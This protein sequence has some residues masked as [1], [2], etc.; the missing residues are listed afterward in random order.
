MGVPASEIRSPTFAIAVEH[1]L[2]GGLRL[3]HA[4]LYRLQGDD[5]LREVGLLDYYRGDDVIVVVEWIDRFPRALPRDWL[6]VRITFDN[7]AQRAISAR[8]HGARARSVMRQW[9]DNQSSKQSL[10]LVGH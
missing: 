8:A 9:K 2:R 3:V 6:E 10:R 4:D 1:P 7:K 5:D